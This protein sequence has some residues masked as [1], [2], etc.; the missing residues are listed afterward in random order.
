MFTVGTAVQHPSTFPQGEYRV[1]CFYGTAVNDIA[2]MTLGTCTKT[3]TVKDGDVQGCSRIYGYKGSTLS[4][5]MLSQSSFDASFRCGSRLASVGITNPYRLAVGSQAP[6]FLQYDAV[7]TELFNTIPL[8][9]VSTQ[10]QN[11][12][13]NTGSDVTCAVKVGDGYSTNNTCKIRTCVGSDCARPQT[14]VVTPSANQMCTRQDTITYDIGCNDASADY[15]RCA[16]WFNST[17]DRTIKVNNTIQTLTCQNTTPP[18]AFGPV[19][20]CAVTLPSGGVPVTLFAGDANSFQTTVYT[21]S[22]DVQAPTGTLEYFTNY[23]AGTKLQQSQYQFW[24]KQSVTA[25][26]TCTDLPGQSDGSSCACAPSLQNDPNGYWSLGQ[27]N[28]DTNVGPD[29]MTY[30]RILFNNSSL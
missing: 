8:G 11:Y 26:I 24:Q 22:R 9:P 4:D 17:G 15:A 13:F 10:T 25:V 1:E 3:M 14:F 20:T 30:S 29:I 21:L 28:T 27:R 12:T 5:E 18:G 2:A 6:A 23:S 16:E 19:R 7:S